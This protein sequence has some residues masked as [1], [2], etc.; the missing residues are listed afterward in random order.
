[1]S[2][3]II[4]FV[5]PWIRSLSSSSKK[6]L[7]YQN[8]HVA[9]NMF[10]RIILINVT[11]RPK[12]YVVW[13]VNVSTR[14]TLEILFQVFSLF[15][16]R[17]VKLPL[18]K[19][20]LTKREQQ[21]CQLTNDGEGYKV[22]LLELVIKGNMVLLNTCSSPCPSWEVKP[23]KLLKLDL[24]IAFGPLDWNFKVSLVAYTYSNS[25]VCS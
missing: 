11:L 7:R 16:S 22:M 4:V 24:F 9:Q 20:I 19:L 14:H 8:I 12:M 21:Y 1:M 6:P 15:Y 18:Y 2:I 13:K 10:Q 23:M 3:Y 17:Q 5:L 25:Q